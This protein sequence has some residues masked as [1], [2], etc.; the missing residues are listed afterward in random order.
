ME[1]RLKAYFERKN[2]PE[3]FQY[4]LCLSF[5]RRLLFENSKFSFSLSSQSIQLDQGF[6][7]SLLILQDIIEDFQYQTNHQT[8]LIQAIRWEIWKRQRCM[9]LPKSFFASPK[10]LNLVFWEKFL[11]PFEIG[12]DRGS[13]N[14]KQIKIISFCAK[15]IQNNFPLPLEVIIMQLHFANFMIIIMLV[16][17]YNYFDITD[18]ILLF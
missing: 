6:F 18:I 3:M 12:G 16:L 5:L 11:H 13:S 2:F 8:Q 4:R 14:I 1:F 10:E 9:K 15:L 17:I 7:H